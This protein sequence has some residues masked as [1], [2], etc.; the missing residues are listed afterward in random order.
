MKKKTQRG[1]QLL[2]KE[3]FICSVTQSVPCKTFA[4]RKCIICI[5]LLNYEVLRGKFV[6]ISMN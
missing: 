1:P 5:I 6:I 3:V 2:G 4:N